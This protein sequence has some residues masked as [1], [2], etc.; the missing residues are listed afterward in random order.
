M[1]NVGLFFSVLNLNGRF[2]A[3]DKLMVFGTISL[4]YLT[5]LLVFVL[6]VKGGTKE[7]K[8]LLLIILGLPISFLLIKVIHLFLFENRPFVTF[9]FIP[10]VAEAAD[11]A[12]FPSRHATIAAVLAFAYTYFKS[13]WSALLLFLMLWIGISRIYVGVHYPLD[14]LGGFIT[15]VA[16]LVIALAIGKILEK[17]FLKI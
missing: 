12:S 2:W 8:A 4:I 15:A 13:K 1:D 14:I 11:S 7:K 16:S 6:A 3:L 10:I 9:H 5:F 17:L